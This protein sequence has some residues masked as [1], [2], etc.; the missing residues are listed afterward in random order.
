MSGVRSR[1]QMPS[2]KELR[3]I[4][5]DF[6]EVDNVK[7]EEIFVPHHMG[8]VHKRRYCKK[9]YIDDNVVSKEKR[10]TI[11]Y[12]NS[13]LKYVVSSIF[14]KIFSRVVISGDECMSIFSKLFVDHLG[15][16]G[17]HVK[18]VE[19]KVDVCFFKISEIFLKKNKVFCLQRKHY[20]H[21]NKKY[22]CEYFFSLLKF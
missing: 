13:C 22:F 3:S 1:P 6:W 20:L 7:D 2:K 12:Y 8:V 10:C 5:H 11:L 16:K 21:A 19:E 18:L 14:V 9:D 4:I 17:E 15:T